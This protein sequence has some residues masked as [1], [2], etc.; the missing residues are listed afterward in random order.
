MPDP[1]PNPT[2]ALAPAPAAAPAPTPAIP[3][4][5]PTPPS[6]GGDDPFEAEFTAAAKEAV[7]APP[8]SPSKT[9]EPAPAAPKAGEKPPA[10]PTTPPAAAKPPEGGPKEL[11]AE[12]ERVRAER[13]NFKLQQAFLE[14]RISEAESKGKDTAAMAERAAKLE[15]TIAE[16]EGELRM[17][18]QEASPEFKDKYDKPFTEAAEYAREVVGQLTV[19]DDSGTTRIATWDDFAALYTQPYSKA[20]D[21]ATAMF[22]NA[23][24]V[25]INHLT[26]LHRLDSVRH[27]ALKSERENAAVRMKDEEGKRVQ[28]QEATAAA[29]AKLQEELPQKFDAYRDPPEDKELSESRAKQFAIF[30]AQPKSPQQ[31]M[32]K[33]AHIRQM[34]GAHKPLL[35]QNS[36]LKAEVARLQAELDGKTTKEPQSHRRPGGTETAGGEESWEQAA[37]KEL[38]NVT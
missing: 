16:R 5:S 37:A 19:T 13:D 17:L 6:S 21:Q 27:R 18:K 12:L 30:D 32:I 7:A 25:V 8:A 11:R 15:Q 28:S 29:L 10:K 2:P 20:I 36:R 22:G 1:I 9:P 4:P 31:A 33:F 34:V 23:A 24:Q 38:G 14:K 3:A 35:I 26:E